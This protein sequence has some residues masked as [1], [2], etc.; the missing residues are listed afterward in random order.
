M[1]AATHAPAAHQTTPP[2]AA[3]LTDAGG[4]RVG[5]FTDRRRPTGCT[6]I[7]FD[8][9]ARAGA[10]Y[11][12]SAPAESL[13]V[14]LQPTSPLDRI[15]AIVLTGGGPMALGATAGVVRFL[16]EQGVGYDWGV[17]NVR[18]PIVVGAAIDD[19]AI[20]D[21]RIRVG[22]DE[23][24]RACQSATTTTVF[25]GSVGA[26]AGATVGKLFVSRG[27]AG[28][29]GGVGCASARLGQTVIAAL[30]VVNAAGD[31]IDW[32]RG[33][34]VA[35]ART[36][37]GRGF[38]RTADVLRRDLESR[39]AANAPLAEGPLR[40]TTLA[41]IATNV[42]FTKTELTKPAMMANTGAARA[43]HPYHTQSDGDQ[44]LAVSTG[45]RPANVSLTAFGAIAAEVVADA[46]VRAVMAATSV[47]GWTAVRDL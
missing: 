23:A 27:M 14:T 6:V 47:A 41:V 34:I 21:G 35:G 2:G 37:D 36:S 29:K 46:V 22:A 43:I 44:M 45:L 15:H 39:T 17:P 24:Y 18:V 28:M 26:G 5:H 33:M 1:A 42:A 13:G 9:P 30:V 4:L 10:D 40:A 31:I 20:G 3:S 38:A 19:L 12:G 8:Q 32:R 7:L 16:E 11:N 25:E